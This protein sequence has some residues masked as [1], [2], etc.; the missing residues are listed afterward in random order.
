ME[1][2]LDERLVRLIPKIGITLCWKFPLVEEDGVISISLADVSLCESIIHI[3]I[4]L[5]ASA[6]IF[7][8][9]FQTPISRMLVEM[10][11]AQPKRISAQIS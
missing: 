7:S 1:A 10:R 9:S 6:L 8:C 5:L 4:T 11:A 3:S 2:K